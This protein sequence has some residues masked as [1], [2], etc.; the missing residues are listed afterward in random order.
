M[1]KKL[2]LWLTY[3]ENIQ[4]KGKEVQFD[5]KGGTTRLPFSQIHSIMFYGSVCP[6]DQEFLEQ[7]AK[8]KIPIVIHRRNMSKA[9]W[10]N[11]STTSNREDLLTKQILFREN[12]KKSAYITKRL[13]KAKFESMT[14]LIPA[15]YHDIYRMT[16]VVQMRAVEAWHAKQYWQEYYH[17][18]GFDDESRR[19]KNNPISIALDATSKFISGI[20]LR[21]VSFHHFS[22]YHG[23][24]HTPSDYPSLV[25]DLMEPYRGYVDQA[26]FEVLQILSIKNEEKILPAVF[27]TIKEKLD[28]EVYVNATRQY[29]T[30]HELYHGL[31]L[32]LRSYLLGN[33]RFIVPMPGKP[34]GGRPIQAGFRLYGKM[35]GVVNLTSS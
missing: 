1:P 18:L 23:F 33:P 8:M 25:Y 16:D 4:L 12:I 30:R 15:P 11:A 20:V 22:P 27:A 21:W 3:T 24:T 14:W 13:L 6:L 2:P 7:T 19:K 34:N 28:E 9:V 31:V 26:V 5:F 10:I 17:R 35:A 29:V 32:G